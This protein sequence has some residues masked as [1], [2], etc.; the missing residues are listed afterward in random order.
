MPVPIVKQ[1]CSWP[2]GR[3]RAPFPGI[4]RISDCV[5]IFFCCFPSRGPSF[6]FLGTLFCST[7][8]E[9]ISALQLRRQTSAAVQGSLKRRIPA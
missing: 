9:R 4:V 5:G 2:A 3:H 6:S 1:C 7:D 8:F